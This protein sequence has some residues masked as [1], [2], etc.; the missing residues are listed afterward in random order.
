M[1]NK[2]AAAICILIISFSISVSGQK[3]LNSPYA[4]YNLGALEPA[5]S[6]RSTAMGG[7]SAGLRDNSAIF[8][9]N[10]ASYSSIDTNSFIFDFGL[11]YGINK[12]S[13]GST[14]HF[15][16]DMNFDHIMI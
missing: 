8:Y 11:D 14:T 6:F 15:T 13:D 2:Q 12:L 10:P 4:R 5:G 3:S 9:L 7:L 1:L 16:N